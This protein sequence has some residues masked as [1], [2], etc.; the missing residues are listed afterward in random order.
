MGLFDKKGP[1]TFNV[2][3]MISKLMTHVAKLVAAG[4]DQAKM[5][6]A[7]MGIVA[8]FATPENIAK[9]T[10]GIHRALLS[11]QQQHGRRYLA[12]FEVA[13]GNEDTVL[14]IMQRHDNGTVTVLHT[15]PLQQITQEMIISL[16]NQAF[17]STDG[18]TTGTKQLAPGQ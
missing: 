5:R 11:L 2:M 7:I 9:T 18:T 10:A 6:R 8:E 14:T 17:A 4:D 13:P 12:A 3:A 15:I 16:I 1:D